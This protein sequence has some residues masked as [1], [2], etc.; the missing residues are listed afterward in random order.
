MKKKK[1]ASFAFRLFGPKLSSACW[2]WNREPSA[3]CHV[4]TLPTAPHPPPPLQEG[5]EGRE[6]TPTALNTNKITHKENQMQ[7][8]LSFWALAVILT[9][10]ILASYLLLSTSLI[11]QKLSIPTLI[12]SHTFPF[13]W[14]KRERDELFLF[15]V[16]PPLHVYLV[17]SHSYTSTS[18]GLLGGFFLSPILPI[19]LSVSVLLPPPHLFPLPLHVSHFS[20]VVLMHYENGLGLWKRN[21]TSLPV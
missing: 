6:K 1:E 16:F 7:S 20:A 15:L 18:F 3:P 10:L 13:S 19:S 9:T 5:G 21:R 4:I 14:P 11:C 17:S 12:F 8:T 2:C